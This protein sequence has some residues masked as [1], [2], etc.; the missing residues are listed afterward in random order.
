MAKILSNKQ[1]MEI[2]D[3]E[4]E[5]M[6]SLG[7]KVPFLENSNM[8]V[9][10]AI[11][12]DKTLNFLIDTGCNVSLFF[13]D[14]LDEV[15]YKPVETGT[16]QTASSFYGDVSLKNI[17]NIMLKIGYGYFNATFMIKEGNSVSEASS[18][19]LGMPI[20]GILGF[21]FLQVGAGIINVYENSLTLFALHWNKEEVREALSQSEQQEDQEED[22]EE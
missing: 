10:Q 8:L 21:P 14:Y 6:E 5:G 16:I 13:S 12:R 18:E 22:Q 20:H 19:N 17:I 4:T 1:F 11:H 9:I 2:L 15:D 7:C 3:K